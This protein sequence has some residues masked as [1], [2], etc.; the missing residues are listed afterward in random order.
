MPARS[1]LGLARFFIDAGWAASEYASKVAMEPLLRRMAPRARKLQAVLT[2]PGFG[3]PE[4]S[5]N[6]MNA[7]LNRQGF[8]A[9]GWGLGTNRGPQDE[10]AVPE[11]VERLRPRLE[12]MAD[13]TG[14]KVAL[15]GQ[16]L[17]GIYAR[18]I[19]RALPQLVD[20][21]VTLGSPAYLRAD[22]IEHMNVVLPYAMRWM[23][24]KAPEHHLSAQEAA[25]LH[26]PPPVPLVAIFSRVDGVVD[27]TTTAIPRG[28][29]AFEGGL[30]RENIEVFASHIG[31]AV[32]PIVLIAVCDR[33]IA[34]AK[35]WKPFDYRRYMPPGA[36]LAG[37]FFYPQRR[38]GAAPTV[39]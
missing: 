33:L 4:I 26:A 11:M 17:G 31:M 7:F 32:N 39:A 36:A 20:R 27:A 21:V 12:R 13:R 29:L 25:I 14:G 3:G 38:P 1:T 34:D 30:P 2:L 23:T 22:G 10:A 18:E 16:S 6:P 37:R 24:G 35:A 19:A 5:L 28:D 9:E 8:H 15:V